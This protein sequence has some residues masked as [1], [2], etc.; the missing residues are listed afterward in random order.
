MLGQDRVAVW[1]LLKEH[2]GDL[3]TVEQRL[4]RQPM[5]SQAGGVEELVHLGRA[6]AMGWEQG[7]VPLNPDPKTLFPA[8]EQPLASTVLPVSPKP[9]KEPNFR[10]KSLSQLHRGFW[11]VFS[12]F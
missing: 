7:D 11:G 1:V 3:L 2:T 10:E 4:G 5:V 12:P 6:V 9:N 8:L